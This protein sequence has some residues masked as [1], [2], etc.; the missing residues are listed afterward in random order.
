ME[1]LIFWLL[2]GVVAAVIGAKK[3]AGG[4]GFILGVLLGPFGILIVL[5]VKGDRKTCPFCRE[6][7]HESAIVCSHCQRDV[8]FKP[9]RPP[10]SKSVTNKLPPPPR[11]K[12]DQGSVV[13]FF[14]CVNDTV[15]GPYTFGDLI[16]LHEIG[17][18]ANDTLCCRE[19][20]EEWVPYE[21]LRSRLT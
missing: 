18:I 9:T 19:G 16:A 14:T 12:S 20:T 1:I 15:S 10:S 11:K 4:T 7:I 8:V 13:Q 2:C 17:D 21:S 6:L 3:G 5:F